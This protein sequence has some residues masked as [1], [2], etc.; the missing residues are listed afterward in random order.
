MI[1]EVFLGHL[2]VFRCLQLL[3]SFNISQSLYIDICDG[4]IR[5][6][7]GLAMM[8]QAINFREQVFGV[9]FVEYGV[10]WTQCKG[11]HHILGWCRLE[12]T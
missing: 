8:K 5:D 12:A 6:L 9:K 1:F 7:I 4:F 3:T 2:N 10:P 11:L